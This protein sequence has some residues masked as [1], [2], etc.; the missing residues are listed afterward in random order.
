MV[1]WRRRELATV[2][3]SS[4]E[5]TAAAVVGGGEQGGGGRRRRQTLRALKIREWLLYFGPTC[6]SYK[7]RLSST[8]VSHSPILYLSILLEGLKQLVLKAY[9]KV[10]SMSKFMRR[11]K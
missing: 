2:G 5:A 1:G 9:I 4:K 11:N 3:A 10:V 8:S 6:L 7:P